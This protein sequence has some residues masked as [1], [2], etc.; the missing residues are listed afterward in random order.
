MDLI[1]STLRL[2]ATDKTSSGYGAQMISVSRWEFIDLLRERGIPLFSYE[3]GELER[4]LAAFDGLA[5]RA[6]PHT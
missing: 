2:F 1:E 5:P 4:E 6:K 3:E